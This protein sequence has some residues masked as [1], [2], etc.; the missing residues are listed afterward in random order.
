MQ[1]VSSAV[2]SH[3]GLRREANE[4]TVCARPDLGLFLVADGMGGHAAGE[5]ASRV[6]A[7]AIE[8]FIN[9]TRE[10]DVNTTWPF[11][12]DTTLSLDGNRLTAA[13]KLANRRLTQAMQ[14]DETLRTMATTAAALLINKGTP[15]VAHVGDSRL[16][17]YRNGTLLQITQ[18]HSWVN[19][20][21][22]AGVLTET[23]AKSHPW[24][25]VVTRALSGGEDPEVEITEVDIK[26]GDR[27]LICSDGLSGVVPP[28]RLAEILERKEPL[29]K[30]CQELIDAANQA[31][32]PDNVTVAV[33]QV[34][35]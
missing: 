2:L 17:R 3:P 25:H 6:A 34:E 19:E 20:Q 1:T 24:R 33:L 5:V 22:R 29:P 7:Q 15:V 35:G 23:D 18:D 31:G 10:A 30:T 26:A 14:E 13:F 4:D 12:Y 32:G 11:P 28:E 8:T 21:V 16:Y 27:L 9:D